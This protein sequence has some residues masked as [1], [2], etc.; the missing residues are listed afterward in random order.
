MKIIFNTLPLFSPLS[1]VGRYL[2]HLATTFKTLFPTFNYYYYSGKLSRTL[3]D[4]SSL[5][6]SGLS[7]LIKLIKG[8]PFSLL[9]RKLHH[10]LT[11]PISETFDLYL[12]A[13][14]IPLPS[15]KAKKILVVVHDFS[16]HRFPEWHPPERVKY[17]ELNFW[18]NLDKANYLICDSRTIYQEALE[19]GLPKERL[20]VIYPGIDHNLFRPLPQIS[21]S[22]FSKSLK[23]PPRFILYV[24]TLEPRKNLLLLLEAYQ[25]LPPLIRK[26]H[27]LLLVGPPGW[28]NESLLESI[29][30]QG[31]LYLGH[32]PDTYLPHLYNLATFLVYPS[33][34]EGF[35]FPPLEAMACGCP[36]LVSDIPVF[37]EVYEEAALYFPPNAPQALKEKLEHLLEDS[38]LREDLK[39]KGLNQASKYSWEK[40]VL[41]IFSLWEHIP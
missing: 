35:G 33:F 25:L 37:R 41:E 31:I 39:T 20:A 38:S 10:L 34:Y 1:G 27:P 19:L 29:K 18:S 3:P 17:F 4:P 26:H 9:L 16:F 13:N 7:R 24:G 14:F 40:T 11:P 32:L 5:E 6:K 12:E 2:Y 8:T 22:L 23:L 28:K 21:L 36:V 30:R 15:I